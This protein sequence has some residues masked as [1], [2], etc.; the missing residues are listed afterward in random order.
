MHI[1]NGSAGRTTEQ[2]VKGARGAAVAAVM[3]SAVLG[4]AVPAQAAGPVAKPAAAVRTTAAVAAKSSQYSYH[5]TYDLF[6][7]AESAKS[8]FHKMN[9]IMKGVFPLKGMPKTV[10]KGQKICLEGG[11]KCNPVLVTKVGQTYFTLKSLP[12]HLEGAGKYITFSLKKKSDDT[13]YLDVR[14]KGP[15]TVWQKHPL[16][17]SANYLFAKASWGLF[18]HQLREVG[19]YNL[20]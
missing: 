10:K 4:A 12:G 16:G 14:A 8:S 3:C 18:A 17:G 2:R 6:R 7:Q 15:K 9:K 11:K 20:I 13:L 19:Q 5:Y 1:Q